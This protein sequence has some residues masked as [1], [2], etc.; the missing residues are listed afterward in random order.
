MI[1]FG[2]SLLASAV[3]VFMG[4]T[5]LATVSETNPAS[6]PPAHIYAHAAQPKVIATVVAHARRDFAVHGL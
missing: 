5:L 4:T 1:R 3:I 6:P 2:S